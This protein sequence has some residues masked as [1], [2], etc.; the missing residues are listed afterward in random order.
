M[1]DLN[2]ARN[3]V[4]AQIRTACEQSNRDPKSVQLL[5]VSKTQKAHVLQQ[6]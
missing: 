6:M 4:L 3:Q 2:Q 5:A 1:N